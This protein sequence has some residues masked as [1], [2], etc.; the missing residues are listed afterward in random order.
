MKG[1]TVVKSRRRT[2]IKHRHAQVDTRNLIRIRPEN[3]VTRRPRSTEFAVPKCLFINIC[4]LAKTKNRVRAPVTL[5]ADLRSQGIGICVVSETHLST[6][7]P[8]AIVNIP[9]YALFR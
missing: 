6:E 7:M 3:I 2:G 9:S 1:I 8:D 5:E 4:G